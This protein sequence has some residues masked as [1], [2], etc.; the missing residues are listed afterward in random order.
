MP[1]DTN[2]QEL[3]P[4]SKEI[5]RCGV[6]HPPED[7]GMKHPPLVRGVPSLTDMAKFRR[8]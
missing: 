2:S 6:C 8:Y 7:V 1:T 5:V 4:S 3:Q